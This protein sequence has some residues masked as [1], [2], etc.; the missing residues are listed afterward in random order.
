MKSRQLS[1]GSIPARRRVAPASRSRSGGGSINTIEA[2][3]ETDCLERYAEMPAAEKI[4]MKETA[5]LASDTAHRATAPIISRLRCR[6]HAPKQAE[7]ERLFHKLPQLDDH[8]RAEIEQF[9]DRLVDT[10][11]H[12]LLESLC[13]ASTSGAPTGLLESLRRLFMIED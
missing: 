9:A 11:L 4:I 3:D 12:P 5:D 6:M 2:S 7:L 1:V 10:I 13:D 8:S